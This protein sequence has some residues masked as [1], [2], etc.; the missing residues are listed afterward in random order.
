MTS[1][2]IVILVGL[3]ALPATMLLFGVTYKRAAPG[4]NYRYGYKTKRSLHSNETWHFAHLYFGRIWFWLGI[5]LS[6]VTIIAM[7]FVLNKDSELIGMVALAVAAAELVGFV[8]SI[9]F[10]ERALKKQFK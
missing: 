9:H 7:L 10:T 5:F 8:L 4:Y 2:W 3:L 6:V 1:Y